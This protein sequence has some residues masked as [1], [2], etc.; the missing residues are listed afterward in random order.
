MAG[1]SVTLGSTRVDESS[2]TSIGEFGELSV[3]VKVSV[4]KISSA[5]DGTESSRL[6]SSLAACP[7]FL[8]S[9]NSSWAAS[10]EQLSS[11]DVDES[12]SSPLMSFTAVVVAG[13]SWILSSDERLEDDP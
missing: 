9:L 13:S 8:S 11:S 10:S 4:T 3:F 6:L 7:Q 5:K 2:S 12:V 1:S